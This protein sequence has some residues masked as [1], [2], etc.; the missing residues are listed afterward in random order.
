MQ[1][2][3]PITGEAT[4]VR[5]RW[6]AS[7][8]GALLAVA[9]GLGGAAVALLGAPRASAAP[10]WGPPTSIDQA[11]SIITAL[12]C[13]SSTLC[14]AGDDTG[15][16]LYS[17]DGAA[18]W[19]RVN[20]DGTNTITSISC[21]STGLCVAV[22]NNSSVLFSTDPASSSWTT[23]P[24]V[25]TY[26]RD[27]TSI[28][29]PSTDLCVFVD[30]QWRAFFSTTPTGQSSA[31]SLD[32]AESWD[33][34]TTSAFSS[35][36]C[37]SSALCVV[38]GQWSSQ[39]SPADVFASTQPTNTTSSTA[40]IDVGDVDG[41]NMVTAVSCPSTSLC[42]AGDNAGNI[43]TAN[44]DP[45]NEVNWSTASSVASSKITAISCPTTSFCVATDVGGQVLVSD[46]PSAGGSSWTASVVDPG[47]ALTS[48]ACASTSFCV[49]GDGSGQVV[50][51]AAPGTPTT[52]VPTTT[53]APATTSSPTTTSAPVGGTHLSVAA[54]LGSGAALVAPGGRQATIR[55]TCLVATCRGS[56][57]LR[58]TVLERIETPVVVHGHQVVRTV[59][60]R[61][62]LTLGA[63][64]YAAGSGVH[65]LSVPLDRSGRLL[66]ARTHRVVV[67]VTV[68]ANGRASV[69]S[70]TL[71]ERSARRAASRNR[72]LSARRS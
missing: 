48:L 50:A 58:A 51:T 27:I 46:N 65:T 37:P 53:S 31:W 23:V 13:P 62:V 18:T 52:G 4:G 68:V 3:G 40:W 42:V 14:V 5:R 8:L 6:R 67:R 59:L 20:V 47:Q 19:T 36:S 61:R 39:L 55:L 33:T 69:R 15:N 28:S 43:L 45:T 60:R 17:T 32:N 54:T 56:V 22:D 26:S 29:C 2:R 71:V 38:G 72:H 7:A 66:L 49:A 44:G 41:K 34:L 70:L 64:T 57:R 10:S 9:L 16:I 12:A 35:I 63:R 25:D 1:A 24:T 30:A 11:S 21:P